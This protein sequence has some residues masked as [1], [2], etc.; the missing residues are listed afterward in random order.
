MDLKGKIRTV[1]EGICPS[2]HD[3]Y[4]L[5][6]SP[7]SI[8]QLSSLICI[9]FSA[10]PLP[11]PTL[12]PD[13]LLP[14]FYCLLCYPTSIPYF[15]PR[16]LFPIFLPYFASQLLL[17]SLLPDFYSLLCFPILLPDFYSL[18]QKSEKIVTC[19]IWTHHPQTCSQAS[20]PLHQSD[21]MISI[22][23]IASIICSQT[24]IP[25]F[26]SRLLFPTLIPYFAPRLLCSTTKEWR[27]LS[28]V[29]FEPIILELAIKPLDHFTNLTW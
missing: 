4:S 6:C 10:S 11:F 1:S 22:P 12:L 5:L 28:L 13:L 29:G 3:F 26:P 19:G 16:L 18:P 20:W 15:A 2:S 8:P 21:L 23:Y 27:N 24:S 17:P 9:H 25:Y 7:T 14:D